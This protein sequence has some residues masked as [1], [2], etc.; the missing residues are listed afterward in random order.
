MTIT[1]NLRCYIIL[2]T[3][4][5]RQINHSLPVK[6]SQTRLKGLKKNLFLL[7]LNNGRPTWDRTKNDGIKI[8]C[9]TISP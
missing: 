6:I 4:R 5:I 1:L 3:H 9:D 8:R 2:A 7:N